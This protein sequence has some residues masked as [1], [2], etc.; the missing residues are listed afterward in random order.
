[1]AIGASAGGLKA[2][3]EIMRLLPED[4]GMAFVILQHLSR[5]FKS[6]MKEILMKD[7]RMEILGIEQDMPL[8]PNRVYLLPAGK[9]LRMRGYQ[10][11]LEDQPEADA[12]HFVIDAFLHSLGKELG[13]R[14]VA[15]ILS[16][17][18]SDG[19]RG[20]QTVKESGGLVIVQEPDSGE[21][22]GMPISSINTRLV[23]YILPPAEIAVRLTHLSRHP[24]P[25]QPAEEGDRLD[26]LADNET[27]RVILELVQKYHEV[28][29][30]LY[31]PGTLSRRIA[32]HM[33]AHSLGSMR[34]YYDFLLRS[35]AHVE[36][37][38]HE[39][40]IGVTEFFRD[41][42]AYEVLMNEIWPALLTEERH[43]KEFR[44]WSCGCSTGEEVYSLLISLL[45]Y[46]ARS[47]V[48]PRYVVLATDVDERALAHASRGRYAPSRMSGLPEALLDKYFDYN[49]EQY[50]VRKR[51]RDSVIFARNDVTV[52]PPFINLDLV[53]CRN[54]LIYLQPAVQRRV[55]LNFHFG[56]K[57]GGYLWLGSSESVVD[58]ASNFRTLDE[59]WKFFQAQGETPRFKRYYHTQLPTRRPREVASVRK[60]ADPDLSLRKPQF[61]YARLLLQRFAPPSILIDS[62]FSVLYLAGGAG[63]Y[64]NIPDSLLDM[65]ILNM[66]PDALVVVLRDALRR[67]STH[68]ERG[69]FLYQGQNMARPGEPPL[70]EDLMVE[71]AGLHLGKQAYL[72]HIVRG[73]HASM[74]AQA[75]I[76][77]EADSNTY[78]IIRGLQEEL[79]IARHEIQAG[80]EE[81][82]TNNEELQAANEELVASNEELQSTNEELQSVN[83]ELYTVNSELQVRNREISEAKASLDNL[84]GSV[85]SGVLFLDK[86][87]CVK[88]FTPE[89]TQFVWL[90]ESDLGMPIARFSMRWDY[91][92]FLADAAQVARERGTLIEREVLLRA[93]GSPPRHFIARLRPFLREGRSDGVI[94]FMV[95]I[96]LRKEAGIALASVEQQQRMILGTIPEFISITE[97]EGR[98]VYI[99]HPAQAL[100]NEQARDVNIF[101]F[102]VPEDAEAVRGAF[103]RA[104]DSGETVEYQNRSRYPDGRVVHYSNKVI[105][106]QQQEG[107]GYNL[108]VLSFDVSDKALA[109]QAEAS[110][111][112][113]LSSY[114]DSLP[115]PVWIK[116]A[117]F[118]YRYA[119][120]AARRE[121]M[122]SGDPIEGRNDFSL[123][124]QPVAE[125]LRRLDLRTLREGKMIETVEKNPARPDSGERLL[126][127][128]FPIPG[129]EGGSF[130]GGMGLDISSLMS[131]YD[132]IRTS[133]ESLEAKIQERTA[134]LLQANEDLRSF[135]R[136]IAHDLRNPIRA[137]V[138]YSQLM[139]ENGAGAEG[140]PAGYADKILRQAQWTGKLIDSLVGFARLGSVAIRR[141]L[142]DMREMAQRVFEDLAPL[143]PERKIELALRECPRAWADA[144]LTRQILTNLFSNAIK[145]SSRKEKALIEFGGYFDEAKFE[146]VYFVRDNGIGFDPR[147]SE[148][149]F[150]MFTRLHAASE[151][152]GSGIGLAIVQRAVQLQNG[153]VWAASQLGNGATFYFSYPH[154]NLSSS[155][156]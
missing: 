41:A 106:F 112:A 66:A 28:D 22:D 42:E 120:A 59:K 83:E 65:N 35:P 3:E 119:N 146:V 123:F 103:R 143:S 61:H 99:N 62:D 145:Y 125:Q 57:P 44:I 19:S 135:T 1:V 111:A 93:E 92:G 107:Q 87:L 38:W 27:Q 133:H 51:L 102:I 89:F 134:A 34:E 16:G 118:R 11:S 43:G 109:E 2:I 140:E 15:V 138:S 95:D 68:Q 71:D 33:A 8:L 25:L 6:L 12:P 55:L 142:L 20:I 67:F 144:E 126:M 23:D 86:N 53:V 129:E 47:G 132:S 104:L 76:P 5:R 30:S 128:F 72:I 50:E 7:T 105:R 64:L 98:L 96:T 90:E 77:L 26:V 131:E 36:A 147:F 139:I 152:E 48:V 151:F 153:S 17:T 24:Q 46:S 136:S 148:K 137:I 154:R 91:P 122:P 21:F 9:K 60:E 69:P 80:L 155:P 84:L 39:L 4:T 79:N 56:L 150:S 58:Y 45:E 74:V 10:F 85:G 14:S 113:L 100:S 149:I 52:D 116:D 31:K 40:L 117:D 13:A 73:E 82:E 110:R 32:K 127:V 108:L 121:W 97:P 75:A 101:E 54:L 78:D 81:L 94:V 124:P 49:G 114:F 156:A 130:V 70:P 141:E 18:G 29:F 115:N 37:L 88:L 63:R